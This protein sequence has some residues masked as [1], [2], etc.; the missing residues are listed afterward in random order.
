MMRIGLAIF[1]K[2]QIRNPKSEKNSEL[3]ISNVVAAFV[4]KAEFNK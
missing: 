1:Y 3:Q 4:P 2:R